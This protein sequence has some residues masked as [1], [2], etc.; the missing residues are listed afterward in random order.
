MQKLWRR[1]GKSLWV[2]LYAITDSSRDANNGGVV[3]EKTRSAADIDFHSQN[4]R[5]RDQWKKLPKCSF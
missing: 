1:E 2:P 4:D 3:S 5:G